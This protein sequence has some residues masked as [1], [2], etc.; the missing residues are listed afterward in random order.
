MTGLS[1]QTAEAEGKRLELLRELIPN[2][3]R[4][5]VISNPTNPYCLIAVEFAERAAKALG[6]R[7]SNCECLDCGPSRQD[8]HRNARYFA[9]CGSGSC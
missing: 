2:L 1:T 9:R 6:P 5:A 3:T 8:L 4:V 7:P